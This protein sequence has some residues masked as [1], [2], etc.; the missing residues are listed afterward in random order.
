MLICSVFVQRRLGD[1]AKKAIGKLT[2][3]TVKKG[4]KVNSY[5]LPHGLAPLP[6]HH[7]HP[8]PFLLI[9]T[10]LLLLFL[11]LFLLIIF[12]LLIPLLQL[13]IL[14]LG[15]LLLFLILLILF[16]TSSSF[17]STSS[18]VTTAGQGLE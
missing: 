16:P 5:T 17:S 18:G 12:L 13:L 15:L 14:L 1:A 3:R 10:I 7:S 8:S 9:L 11:L 2:T 4:D 6:V